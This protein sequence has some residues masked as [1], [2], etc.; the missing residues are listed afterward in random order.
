MSQLDGKSKDAN[1]SRAGNFFGPEEL[2]KVCKR[3]ASSS[4]GGN[5][6]N[7]VGKAA[8][9]KGFR[10]TEDLMPDSGFAKIPIF[11]T[12]GDQLRLSLRENAYLVRN[13]PF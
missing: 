2:F 11:V 4:A 5:G 6:L 9:A 7:A 12:T 13:R 8:F 1:E 3:Y 10:E